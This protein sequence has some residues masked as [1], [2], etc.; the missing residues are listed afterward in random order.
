M[1]LNTYKTIQR[2]KLN[3]RFISYFYVCFRA[4]KT[5]IWLSAT[6]VGI[7][8][9]PMLVLF[10][11]IVVHLRVPIVMPG[12]GCC[13]IWVWFFTPP[14]PENHSRLNL[15]FASLYRSAHNML[16]PV[17]IPGRS[18]WGAMS[19]YAWN[20]CILDSYQYMIFIRNQS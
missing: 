12:G 6:I 4:M 18:M 5:R 15:Y 19:K 11:H 2:K 9:W 8:L 10:T 13:R 16:T 1:I 20:T 14:L 7:S 3:Y 17:L